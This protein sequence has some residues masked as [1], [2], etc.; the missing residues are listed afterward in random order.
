MNKYSK[1]YPAILAIFCASAITPP[2]WAQQPGCKNTAAAA[3]IGGLFG[4]L[5]GGNNK[6]EGAAIGAAISAIACMAI[7][8]SSKQ[9]Q[10]S[11]DVLQD[12]QAH[13]GGKAPSTVTLMNYQGKSPSSVNRDNGGSV[14]VMSTGALVVP[15][16]QQSGQFVEEIQL[17]VPGEQSPVTSKKPI[18][19]QGGGGFEQ[20]FKFQLGK[21]FPQGLYTYKTRVMSSDNRVLGERSGQFQVI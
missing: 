15:P 9:T 14:E 13:N 10:S 20:S 12:Y 18:A 1:T 7:D 19:V 4:A 5:A 8:G 6:A 17:S 16:G 2:A 11:A 3:A 21:T